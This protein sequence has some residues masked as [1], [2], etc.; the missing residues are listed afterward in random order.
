M[1]RREISLS[2]KKEST[3]KNSLQE[4]TPWALVCSLFL[5]G[6]L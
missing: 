5:V 4:N 3:Y 6:P 1:L 2:I